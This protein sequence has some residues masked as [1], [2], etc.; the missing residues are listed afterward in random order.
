MQALSFTLHT[1]DGLPRTGYGAARDRDVG[2]PRDRVYEEQLGRAGW[3]D[4]DALGGGG[5]LVRF[6]C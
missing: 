2:Y 1:E 3:R 4:G 6:C 5:D